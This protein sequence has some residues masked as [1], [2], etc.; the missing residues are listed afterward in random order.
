MTA[1]TENG[2]AEA[3]NEQLAKLDLAGRL[4]LVASLGGR[5]VFTTSLGIEDQVGAQT[6]IFCAELDKQPCSDYDFNDFIVEFDVETETVPEPTTL[7]LLAGALF[8]AAWTQ[9]RRR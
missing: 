4:A 6:S 2:T 7:T 3:L 8:A 9:R 1:L 5:S